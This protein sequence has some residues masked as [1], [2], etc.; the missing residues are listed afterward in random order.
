MSDNKICASCGSLGDGKKSV[1]GGCLIEI[2]LWLF[3]LPIGVI[4]S[5]WRM[6]TKAVR[7]ES[8]DS[9]EVISMDSPRGGK[10]YREYYKTGSN[11]KW[12]ED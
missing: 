8:C 10:L 3:F 4:Y 7:C 6:C 11:T 5:I 12:G 2:V 9:K 1:K